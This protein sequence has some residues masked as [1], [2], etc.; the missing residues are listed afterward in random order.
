LLD[1]VLDMLSYSK[2][3]EPHLESTDVGQLLRDCVDLLSRRATERQVDLVITSDI[4]LFALLDQEGIFRAITNL[5]TNAIDAC[6]HQESG[7]VELRAT[8]SSVEHR[9]AIL[10]ADN[11]VGMN[12]DELAELFQPFQSTKGEAGT[13]LG[14]AVSRK[15]VREHG[16]DITVTSQPGQGSQFTITLPYHRPQGFADQFKS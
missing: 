4:E 2:P 14:L 3:R 8:F 16:G 6:Q 13:G 9:L 15:I 5:V 10:I 12:S 7:R 11:G 1:L